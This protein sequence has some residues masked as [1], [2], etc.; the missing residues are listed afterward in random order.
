M[1]QDHY[2]ALLF[3]TKHAK[4]KTL[5]TIEFIKAVNAA[6]LKQTG[7]V[8]Q[9]VFGELDAAKSVYRK[10]NVSTGNSYFAG[11]QKIEEIGTN[12]ARALG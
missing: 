5:V 11:Y 3:V 2:S 8:Y 7:S 9:T 12:C 1:V 6:V 10:A 4:E